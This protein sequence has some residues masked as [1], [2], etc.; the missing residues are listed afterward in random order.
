MSKLTPNMQDVLEKARANGG[1]L[2]RVVHGY[3]TWP[4]CPLMAA[5]DWTGNHLPTWFVKLATI[6]ALV[7]R[8]ELE[9]T[10][11]ANGEAVEVRLP[12]VPA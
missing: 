2:V 12:G 7:K 3:W 5:P 4:D 1:T 6:D 9:V 11:R 10:T 8:G